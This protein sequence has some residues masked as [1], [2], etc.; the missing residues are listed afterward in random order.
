[1]VYLLLHW[2]APAWALI[3]LLGRRP[4]SQKDL[5]GMLGRAA[6]AAA[7]YMLIIAQ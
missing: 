5:R 4:G 3:G 6:A 7:L 1:M 2:V